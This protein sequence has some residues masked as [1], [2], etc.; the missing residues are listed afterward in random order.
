MKKIKLG[1]GF[2]LRDRRE[3]AV[4]FVAQKALHDVVHRGGGAVGE[5]NVVRI[6]RVAVTP[7]DEI[8]HHLT[9]NRCALRLGIPVVKI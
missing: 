8:S 4:I 5:E 6:R 9:A 1:V 2:V 3:D 7:L